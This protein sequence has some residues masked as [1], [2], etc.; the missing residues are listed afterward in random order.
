MLSAALCKL[1]GFTYAPSA[2][3]W[4]QQGKS[5]ERDFIYVTTQTLNAAQLS[6]LSDDV[7]LD[8]TLLVCCGAFRG[9]ADGYSNLTI[10]K[11]PKMVLRKCEWGH[12]DYRLQR[13]QPAGRDAGGRAQRLSHRRRPACSMP[14]RPVDERSSGTRHRRS[15]RRRQRRPSHTHSLPEE[16]HCPRFVN[17]DLIAAGLSPFAPEAAAVRA[18]RLMLEE[19]DACI[20]RGESF[21]FET[22]L[23]GRGYLRR[24]AAWRAAG[25][26]VTLF[27]LA[28][29]DAEWAI[30]R[31]AERVRQGG[32]HVPDD[33]VRRQLRCGPQKLRAALPG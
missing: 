18:G 1:E 12:D 6:A 11:I 27:F 29:P 19:I 2:D 30:S 31:V 13:R 14:P 9:A 8:R 23:A 26:H 4:W 15:E 28:L 21:A 7:G 22:T 5:T 32:H 24:I 20:A 10:R 33:V 17:A 3:V 16:A 25:W